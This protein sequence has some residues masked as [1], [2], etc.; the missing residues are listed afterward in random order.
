M[1]DRLGRAGRER[2]LATGTITDDSGER[3][4]NLLW[5]FPLKVRVD[6][7]GPVAKTLSFAGWSQT[8][9]QGLS[10]AD[11]GLLE[12]LTSDTA[13]AI[14]Y[15]SARGRAP[16]LLGRRFRGRDGSGPFDIF[17]LIAPVDVLGG[18][19][20]T[21]KLY[22]FDSDSKMLRM[23]RYQREIDGRVIDVTTEVS[24]WSLFQGQRIPAIVTRIEAG[25]R[26]FTI[27]IV[28]AALQPA[29]DDGVFAAH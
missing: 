17:E 14:I 10:R 20:P 18:I 19:T 5:E 3:R 24:S 2:V 28:P 27:Q 23:V 21:K 6:Q 11:L 8:A 29:V 15:D 1:G 16:E 26:L 7:L 25:T 22:L 9:P 4:V 12:S 13:E